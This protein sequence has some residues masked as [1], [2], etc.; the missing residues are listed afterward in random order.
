MLIFFFSFVCVCLCFFVYCCCFFASLHD[1]HLRLLVFVER[2]IPTIKP[3][4][5][6]TLAQRQTPALLTTNKKR[7][8][9]S[10]SHSHSFSIKTSK[11]LFF[12]IF[13]SLYFYYTSL[14]HSF[15]VLFATV[16][17]TVVNLDGL[18]CRK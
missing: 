2:N 1:V 18:T 17:P 9:S 11:L 3:N 14:A 13:R 15:H 6:N 7:S 8:N 4:F 12:L 16:M 5:S 10:H